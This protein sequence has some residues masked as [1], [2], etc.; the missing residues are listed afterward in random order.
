[1]VSDS[2]QSSVLRFV[3]SHYRRGVNRHRNA[4]ERA[5]ST[6]KVGAE[7]GTALIG[8][9]IYMTARAAVIAGQ[10]LRRALDKKRLPTLS[11]QARKVLNF[12]GFDG[13]EEAAVELDSTNKLA[14]DVENSR[15]E[16]RSGWPLLQT[17]IA[18][19]NCLSS[20][21]LKLLSGP[22][23]VPEEVLVSDAS[24]RESGGGLAIRGRLKGWMAQWRASASRLL[25]FETTV[26]GGLSTGGSKLAVVRRV[27]GVASDLESRSLV[28]VIDYQT[29]WKG[30]SVLQQSRLRCK[31]ST[32]LGAGEVFLIKNRSTVSLPKI[33][34][35]SL[36]AL[37][38][39][40]GIPPSKLAGAA[41]SA[42][43]L[44][45]VKS[46][47]IVAVSQPDLNR[48]AIRV[49]KVGSLVNQSATD[50]SLAATSFS[51]PMAVLDSVPSKLCLSR[52]NDDQR[53]TLE[54]DVISTTYVEHPLEK[55]LKWIDRVLLWVEKQW[56][57]FSQI[58][59]QKI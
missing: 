59:V 25:N 23:E 49:S 33:L 19:G 9:P 7:L 1:M 57:K 28:L 47:S 10:K 42:V 35:V 31:I 37:V 40:L 30:L 46:S 3:V 13:L 5:N 24:S 11:A 6:V 34:Q 32:F 12:S 29:A 2:Y 39:R 8:L 17:L 22:E 36:S 44:A 38:K 16:Q 56:R 15:L 58:V 50:K 26:S 51:T 18:V 53:K 41:R 54:A 45:A 43:K 20:R 4:F 52:L 14:V 55:L 27:T 21:Q 48:S